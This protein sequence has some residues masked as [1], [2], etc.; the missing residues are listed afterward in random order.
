MLIYAAVAN[1]CTLPGRQSVSALSRAQ[2]KKK[3]CVQSSK[4]KIKFLV[5]FPRHSNEAY[6]NEVSQVKSSRITLH[7]C[8]FHWLNEPTD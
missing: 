5:R 4:T 7:I 6:T 2:K 3:K 1:N 8:C